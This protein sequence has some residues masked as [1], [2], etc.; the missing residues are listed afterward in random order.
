[1]NENIAEMMRANVARLAQLKK[2]Q[3]VWEALLKEQSK[4]KPDPGML[5][6]L[7][8][9]LV[10]W[11]T[12][13]REFETEWRAI[14]SGIVDGYQDMLRRFEGDLRQMC[15]QHGYT[16]QG[17]YPMLTVDGLIKVQIDKERAAAT[18]N[19]KKATMLSLAAVMEAVISEYRRLWERPFEYGGYLHR[20]SSAYREA[21]QRE[22][23]PE[24]E[25]IPL[26]DVYQ[27]LR[28][29]DAKYGADM[30]AADLSRLMEASAPSG[31]QIL[32]MAPV[33]DTK[34]AVYIY[35]RKSK[36]GRYV[37]LVSF[38]RGRSI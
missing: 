21:C 31:G 28:V 18:V 26:R 7:V 27:I 1:M 38:R 22:K 14:E 9:Q 3:K 25:F 37:G 10:G 17:E 34:N 12:V 20:L 23:L 24:A 29:A 33:R 30:F 6:H 16:L 8:V 15:M 32:E 13:F 19:G 4:E 11:P 2:W 5:R 35:D 36:N